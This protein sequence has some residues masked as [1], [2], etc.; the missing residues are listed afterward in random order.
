MNAHNVDHQKNDCS[1]SSHCTHRLPQCTPPYGSHV[2]V[3]HNMFHH[4]VC[5]IYLTGI[6]QMCK[7]F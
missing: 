2:P 1:G 7:L 5:N 3:L 4:A 6:L